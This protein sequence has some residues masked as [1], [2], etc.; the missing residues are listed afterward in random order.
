M[1]A[2]AIP[3]FGGPE[4]LSLVDVPTPEPAPGQ[5]TIDV[6]HAGANFAEVLYRRGLVEVALPFVPGIEVAGHI[7][8]VGA[9]V[10]DLTPGQPVA[11]LTIV[12]SGG[13]A[14]VARTDARLVA[15]LPGNAG[16][17]ELALASGIPSNTTTAFMV[18]RDVARMRAGDALLVHAAAGGVGSQIGQ[19]AQLLGASR[20]IGVV[21]SES[22]RA[23]AQ[24]FGYDEVILNEE[25]DEH[26]VNGGFDVITD[27]VGGQSRRGSLDRLA[28][29]GRLVA[30]GNASGEED[31]QVSAN[32]LW[33]AGTGVLGFNL[34]AMSAARASD[35][36]DVLRAAVD[37]V[38]AGEVRVEV[39]A[40]VPL[41]RA[42]EAHEK[43]ES[44]ASTG[45]IV[46]DVQRRG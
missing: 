26:P 5:V 42:P 46:L 39:S 29:G 15:A 32:E 11:A 35:V 34:A 19:V 17:D 27:M 3:R 38:L 14:E 44:R 41:E 31:V 1:K 12:D 8:A 25:L 22:K 40:R 6:T 20:V 43:L 7:R 28:L 9:G 4:V 23:A 21:G 24:R 2:V 45:K 10:T 37:A 36:G 18:L 30:M 13:Y 33:L 16:D